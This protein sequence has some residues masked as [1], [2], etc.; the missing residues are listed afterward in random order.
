MAVCGLPLCLHRII[1][2]QILQIAV[3]G[4]FLTNYDFKILLVLF[5]HVHPQKLPI[6]ELKATLLFPSVPSVMANYSC[7]QWVGPGLGSEFNGDGKITSCPMTV[8]E[9]CCKYVCIMSNSYQ[10]SVSL[11]NYSMAPA[12]FGC[13]DYLYG[14]KS[15]DSVDIV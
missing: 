4:D 1:R 5:V 12:Y 13:M 2:G 7:S 9:A 8:S 10:A 11:C 15:H 3:V 6:S 14:P